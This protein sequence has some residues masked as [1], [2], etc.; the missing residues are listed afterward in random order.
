MVRH[1]RTAHNAGGRIQGHL[2]I[3]L[4][5]TGLRQA[6]TIAPVL[7]EVGVSVL[8]TSDLSRACQTADALA[9]AAGVP[10]VVDARLRELHL[11]AWQGLTLPEAK[12]QFAT[13]YAAWRAGQDVARGGGE[14]YRDGAARAVACIEEHLP[15]AGPGGTLVAVTHGATARATLGALLDMPAEQWWRLQGLGN[16]CW[17]VLAETDRGWRLERHN[18]RAPGDSPAAAGLAAPLSAP[19]LAPLSAPPPDASPEAIDGQAVG[20]A[21]YL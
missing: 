2:D 6:A 15:A 17:S 5:E 19:L 18:V 4:D 11:G 7:A 12:E 16:A 13:E 10:A 1:G 21:P 20:A 9:V 8:L 3:P 14:T